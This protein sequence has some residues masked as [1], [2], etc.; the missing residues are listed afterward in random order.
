MFT[1]LVGVDVLL[2]C[3]E[4]L[5]WDKFFPFPS[6]LCIQGFTMNEIFPSVISK[7]VWDTI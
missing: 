7:K 2:W 5:V 3:K 4:N 6:L 1:G